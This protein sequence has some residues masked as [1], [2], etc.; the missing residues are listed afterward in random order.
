MSMIT[1][2]E[3]LPSAAS[4]SPRSKLLTNKSG[5][6]LFRAFVIVCYISYP[7][8]H[9]LDP[10]QWDPNQEIRVVLTIKDNQLYLLS[11]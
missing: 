11:V 2:V 5:D 3:S 8:Q 10:R 9:K 1:V 7:V 4:I 6:I